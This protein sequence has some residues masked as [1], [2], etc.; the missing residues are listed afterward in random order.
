M[1]A[2]ALS[3]LTLLIF[4]VLDP[5]ADNTDRRQYLMGCSSLYLTMILTLLVQFEAYRD[6]EISQSSTVRMQKLCF[7]TC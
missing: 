5:L 6:T 3:A 7:G 4:A 1:A 2:C